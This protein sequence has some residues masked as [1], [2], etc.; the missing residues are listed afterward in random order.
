[1]SPAN[2]EAPYSHPFPNNNR[3][4]GGFVVPPHSIPF[5]VLLYRRDLNSTVCSGSLI[6]PNY[7]LTAAH[8][9]PSGTTLENL[10][11][12]VGEHNKT[13]MGDG[14][15][16]LSVIKLSIHPQY[17]S[18]SNNY[19]FATIQ[20]SPAVTIPYDTL[21]IVCLPPDVTQTF[22]GTKMTVSGWG[23]ISSNGSYSQVLKAAFVTGIS[24]P[25]CKVISYSPNPGF[26][27]TITENTLCA[28]APSVSYCFGDSGGN[29]FYM[30]DFQF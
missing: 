18:D 27:V 4:V 3:I 12:V 16:I 1:M 23:R 25:D 20:I 7:I 6:S 21:G 15:Q 22:V 5:Q 11:I 24:N 8:C 14:E 9:L 29:P 26:S 17:K 10:K 28:T 30:L 19:D 2:V 13:L